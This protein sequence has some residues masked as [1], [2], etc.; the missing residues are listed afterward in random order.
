M[1]YFY[2]S[3]TALWGPYSSSRPVLLLLLLLSTPRPHLSPSSWKQVFLGLF[4]YLFALHL[5]PPPSPTRCLGCNESCQLWLYND[6][7][8]LLSLSLSLSLSSLVHHLALWRSLVQASGLDEI[9]LRLFAFFF[10]L[11]STFRGSAWKQTNKQTGWAKRLALCD[12][13][14]VMSRKAKVVTSVFQGDAVNKGRGV[15]FSWKCATF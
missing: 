15:L 11:R 8:P 5:S 6:Q 13:D 3:S 2:P 12:V 1:F 14:G 10:P 7:Q 4:I 9:R